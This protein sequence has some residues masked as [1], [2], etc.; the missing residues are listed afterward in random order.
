MLRFLLLQASSSEAHGLTA[1]EFEAAI[2]KLE[3]LHFQAVKQ[4][5]EENNEGRSILS[6][7]M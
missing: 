7:D 6:S 5:W 4:W 1:D 3:L 2:D